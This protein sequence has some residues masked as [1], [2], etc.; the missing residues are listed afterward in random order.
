MNCAPRAAAPMSISSRT[1]NTRNAS[2]NPTHRLRRILR[3]YTIRRKNIRN[4]TIVVH[5]ITVADKTLVA[6]KATAVMIAVATEVV[7]AAGGVALDAAVDAVG[8]GAPARVARAAAAIFHRPNT[9][10]HRVIS[11]GTIRAAT[12]IGTTVA[13]VSIREAAATTTEAIVAVRDVSIIAA[14]RAA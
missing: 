3:R 9:P 4:A 2:P 11:A 1:T 6:T 8:A 10:R 13:I 14:P 5:V 7:T 12:T